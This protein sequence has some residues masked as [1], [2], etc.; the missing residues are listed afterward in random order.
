[1]ILAI[2]IGNSNI[3]IG[4]IEGEKPLFVERIATDRKKT[5]LEYA[6]QFRSIL[7]LNGVDAS[8]LEGGIL[9]SV[10]PPLT[11]AIR[12]SAERIL[13]KKILTVGPGLKTGLNIAI[14]NPAQLGSDQVV[15]AVAAIACYKAP[16]IVI[17]M[18][19]ATTMSAIDS[20]GKYLGGAIIPGLRVALDSLTSQ[21][22][23]L[24][25]ISL[26]A[27]P[28]VIGTNTVDCMQSGAILGNASLLD[29][30]IDRIQEEL[31]ETCTVVATGGLVP[32]VIPHCRH[33]IIGD[34]DLL[35]KGL[36]ILY[37]KNTKAH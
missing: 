30:M 26:E 22:S 14:D 33:D 13:G 29:G 6:L 5:D 31:G 24:P 15:D 20:T 9:S 1:M 10:V 12:T 18:G 8:S 17:D 11:A 27:P 25:N 21:T 19:T 37:K 36:W 16:L 23:Q 7:E 3:V 35:L 4:C 28:H 32:F 2:D 34:D